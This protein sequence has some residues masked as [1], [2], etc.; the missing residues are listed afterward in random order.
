MDAGEPK[1]IMSQA[2]K[3]ILHAE[4]Q[5]EVEDMGR[6]VWRRTN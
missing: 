4:R 1:R 3:R 6:K 2:L 5:I